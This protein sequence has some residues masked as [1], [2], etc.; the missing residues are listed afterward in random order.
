MKTTH[1]KSK[2]LFLFLFI[3]L[4]SSLRSQIKMGDHPLSLDPYA[5]F[6]IESKDKGV[7]F[8]RMTTQERDHAFSGFVPN[9]LLIFNSDKGVFEY[10]LQEYNQWTSV[11]TQVPHLSLQNH[12]HS[13]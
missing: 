5:I 6:E 13:L 11:I 10:Y 9:S 4:I 3:S 2:I 12:L 1:S 7:L 8:P